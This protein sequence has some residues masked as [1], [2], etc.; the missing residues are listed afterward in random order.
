MRVLGMHLAMGMPQ[1]A[2]PV[3]ACVAI[4]S[5]KVLMAG[6]Y[7]PHDLEDMLLG[8]DRRHRLATHSAV[9]LLEYQHGARRRAGLAFRSPH[10]AHSAHAVSA[11]HGMQ[12]GRC[13]S[14]HSPSVQN[15][16][17][18]YDMDCLF[19]D[20]LATEVPV[21]MTNS[22]WINQRSGCSVNGTSS[23]DRADARG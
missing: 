3:T 4:S 20:A 23:R 14:S 1:R 8:W 9:R 22:E 5:M 16:R 17:A 15:M 18:V 6:S 11:C 12:R 13:T 10:L 7:R 19:D 21:A 2:S